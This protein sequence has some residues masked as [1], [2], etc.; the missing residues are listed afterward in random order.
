MRAIP[1]I[2]LRVW[3]K[4]TRIPGLRSIVSFARLIAQ[5]NRLRHLSETIGRLESHCRALVGQM[6]N[7][8][9][10]SE[11]RGQSPDSLLTKRLD[12]FEF[13][14]TARYHH[15]Y[16]QLDLLKSSLEI[17]NEWFDE[18]RH[19]KQTHPL[20]KHPLVSVCVATWNRSQLLTERSI[21]SLLAQTYKQIEIVVVGDCC[22]DD[23]ERRLASMNDSR[24]RF[25]NR[26]KRGAYPV[27]ASRR[28]QVAG[29]VPMNDALSYCR[30]DFVTHL[31]D[32]DEH[33]PT[34]I[35][36][37]L[38]FATENDLDL[39]WHPFWYEPKPGQ[40]DL[41]PANDLRLTQVTT[42]SILYR[43]WLSRILWDP[44][45][46]L[47]DEPG[48]WN[49]IRKMKYLGV[50]SGRYPDPLLRHFIECNQTEMI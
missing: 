19:W 5:I 4:Q 46:H 41:C 12:E 7:R 45:S 48:D 3:L 32:D 1:S 21:P 28:W 24:I 11:N 8:A 27:E 42:S 2:S 29:S 18:F 26:S 15:L 13:I 14:A 31:D 37:L 38:A 9:S 39:I 10:G 36:K 47:L 33:D 44:R 35:E 16:N 22:T 43:S 30:G 25:V 49:R 23:T 40:W 17:P 34:R 20:P 50:K 6:S